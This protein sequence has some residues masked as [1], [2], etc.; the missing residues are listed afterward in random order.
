MDDLARIV[1]GP[2]KQAL[3]CALMAQRFPA[4]RAELLAA[5]SRFNIRRTPPYQLVQRAIEDFSTAAR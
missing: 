1:L 5:A 2:D 4:K 3:V